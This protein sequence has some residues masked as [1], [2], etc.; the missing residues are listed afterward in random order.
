[1]SEKRIIYVQ[2]GEVK[3]ST[4]ETI[5]RSSALGSCVVVAAYD[6]KTQIGGFAH[7][8]LPGKAPKKENYQKTRYADDAIE[9]L[10]NKMNLNGAKDKN[11]ELCLAGG[12][13]VLK[14]ENDN[15]AQ[16]NIDNVL[17]ILKKK[18]YKIRAKSVGGM[19]R[20]NAS[21]DIETACLYYTIGNGAEMLLCNFLD[22][23]CKK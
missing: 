22:E 10:L 21:L 14:K 3:T 23:K 20:R 19:E 13:N 15:I 9:D 2:T 6:L 5:L 16:N 17:E 8:M 11:I 4:K 12:A 1:M 18:K 7:I